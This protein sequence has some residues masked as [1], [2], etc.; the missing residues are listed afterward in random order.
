MR[1]KFLCD[2]D[3]VVGDIVEPL[4]E[5]ANKKF[6]LNVKREDIVY[7]NDMGRSPNLREVDEQLREYYPTPG[8]DGGWGGAFLEFMRQ[9]DV[10]TRYVRPIKDAQ[11]AMKIISSRADCLFVTALMKRAYVHVPNKLEWISDNFAGIPISTMPSD[12]KQW[13]P[14][15][16]AVDDRYDTC[17]RWCSVGTQALMFKQPWSEAPAGV[18]GFDWEGI[19]NVVEPFMDMMERHAR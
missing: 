9:P 16:F 3:G 10:Y 6:S 19:L 2:V 17:M 18:S 14:G 4:V 7:H 12:L 1:I 15:T 8:P 11:R 13:I 5:W